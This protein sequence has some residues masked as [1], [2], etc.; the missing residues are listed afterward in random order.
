MEALKARGLSVRNALLKPEMMVTD[1]DGYGRTVSIS[2]LK[3]ADTPEEALPEV[4]ALL[5]LSVR[6]TAQATLGPDGAPEFHLSGRDASQGRMPFVVLS[7]VTGNL[8]ALWNAIA[9]EFN[10]QRATLSAL[11][12]GQGSFRVKV[13]VDDWGL[14]SHIAETYN[15]LAAATYD[16]GALESLL[17][18]SR[19]RIAA[20][21]S[22]YLKAIEI[23]KLEVLGK[24]R[25]GAAF[26][27]Y[28]GARRARKRIR[29]FF[30]APN[31]VE[32]IKLRGY[33]EGWGRKPQHFEFYDIDNGQRLIGSVS[34]ALGAIPLD[35]EIILGHKVLYQ[36]EIQAVPQSGKPQPKYTLLSFQPIGE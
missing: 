3:L 21:Y 13:H 23:N 32:L 25:E 2:R 5:P 16:E 36:V 18:Q 22:E 1:V 34:K 15:K 20:A 10:V 19:P 12:F 24:W 11:A 4:G 27:G 33:L 29:G 31:K 26:V 7:L 17:A 35:V 9:P 8:Q 14:F 30:N 28:E 6:T